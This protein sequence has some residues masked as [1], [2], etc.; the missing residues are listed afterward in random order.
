MPQNENPGAGGVGASEIAVHAAKLN[1]PEDSQAQAG[2]QADYERYQHLREL[3]DRAT[4]EAYRRRRTSITA[5][6]F[7]RLAA[8]Y[9]AMAAAVGGRLLVTDEHSGSSVTMLMRDS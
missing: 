4:Y 3:A 5:Q 9:R 2:A 1:G 7:E 6:K 8:V